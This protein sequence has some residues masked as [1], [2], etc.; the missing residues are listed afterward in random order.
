MTR[1]SLH[2]HP[3]VNFI[4][5]LLAAFTR[6]DPENAK[7]G[8]QLVSLFCAFGSSRTKAVCKMLVK[9]TPDEV[10][11]LVAMSESTGYRVTHLV[12]TSAK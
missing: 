7:K 8:S 9:L 1:N 3:R 6:G 5:I 4:N 10:H 2:R 12:E 11:I